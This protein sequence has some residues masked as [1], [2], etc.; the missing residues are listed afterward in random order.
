VRAGIHAEPLGGPDEQRWRV[1][2]DGSCS[3]LSLPRLSH[4]LASVPSGSHVTVELEVDFLDH[5]VHDTLDAWRRRHVSNGGTVEIEE[6]GTATLRDA[7]DGP[8]ARGSSRSALRGGFAPWRSWQRHGRPGHAGPTA[9][10]PAG[11]RPVLAGVDNY[12]RRH[13][14]LLRPHVQELSAGQNPDTLFLTC[15]DSRLVPNLITSSGPGDLFTVRN[16]GNVVGHDRLDPSVEAALEFALNELSVKSVVICGHSGCG[17]MSALMAEPKT[18]P[19]R[20]A[21]DVAGRSPVDVWLDHARPSMAAFRA[22]H[23]VQAD[24]ASAGYAEVDQLAMVNVA[25]QLERLQRHHGLQQA[26]RSGE[27]HLTGLF[28]DIATARVLQVTTAGISHLDPLPR[29][30]DDAGRLTAPV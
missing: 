14:H 10:V 16:V 7:Q 15:A 13:A 22:G 20:P 4:V 21:A 27:L 17:A 12:H 11:L 19:E 8:P 23:P 28:Y 29:N 3:F 24:A 1:V 26:L 9:E 25:I 2:I 30:T 5:P 6:S 18:A